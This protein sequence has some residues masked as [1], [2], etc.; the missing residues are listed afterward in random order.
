MSATTSDRHSNPIAY[1]VRCQRLLPSLLIEK[2]LGVPFSPSSQLYFQP[3]PIMPD[4]RRC[5]LDSS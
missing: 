4:P 2:R 3:A 1:R 5:S